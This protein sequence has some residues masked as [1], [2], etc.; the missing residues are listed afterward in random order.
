MEGNFGI[1][2]QR[3]KKKTVLCFV[4]VVLGDERLGRV[5]EGRVTKE[6]NLGQTRCLSDE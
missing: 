5:K 6:T 2:R 4:A 3:S 1:T